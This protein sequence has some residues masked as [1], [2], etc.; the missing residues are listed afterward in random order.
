M[1]TTRPRTARPTPL[2]PAP[3]TRITAVSATLV[4]IAGCGSSDG[5]GSSEGGEPNAQEKQPRTV[6]TMFGAV[7]IPEPQDGDLTV[8]ALGW[9]DA[10]TALALDVVPAA[11]V[12]W[13]GFGP[14]NG[15]VGPWA[16]ERFAGTEPLIIEQ[17]NTSLNYEQIQALD[18]DLI[19]NTRSDNDKQEFERL[20][21]IA[22]TVY[23]PKGTGAFATDWD[24]QTELVGKAVGKRDE[25]AALVE[26][27]QSAIDEAAAAHPGFEG[28]SVASAAKFGDAYGAYLPGDGRFDVLADLG[29]VNNPPIAELSSS[30]FFAEVS[31]ENVEVFDADAAVVLPIGYTLK[32]ATSDELLASLDVVEEGRAVF[33]DPDSELAGAWGASSVLSIPVVLDELAPRLADAVGSSSDD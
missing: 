20:S 5:A 23:G 29:L 26:D 13:Q 17:G 11:T 32:E 28:T 31:R 30:G 33:I 10:E 18:P 21:Q 9:S 3:L 8:V 14:D 24:V 22:P 2:S 7:E 16:T 27:T 4:L 25:A 15:G 19:L 6:Q 1:R 12:D